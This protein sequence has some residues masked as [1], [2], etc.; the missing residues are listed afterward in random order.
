[1]SGEERIL[2]RWRLTREIGRGGMGQVWHAVLLENTTPDGFPNQAAIKILP[3]SLTRE[4]GIALRFQREM[5]I[6]GKLSH[7]GIVTFLEATNDGE[8]LG[9]AMEFVDGCSLQELLQSRGALDW[10]DVLALA[11][12]ICQPLKHAHDRG[13]IHRD[14]KPSNILVKGWPDCPQVKLTDFGVASLFASRKLTATGGL[15]G[16]AETIA[17]E[18]V[19]GKPAT[20]RSDLYSLGVVI[21]TL[22]T[23]QFP[24]RGHLAEVLHKQRFGQHERLSHLVNGLPPELERLVDE[25]LAKDP[26]ARPPDA[27]LVAR[28]LQVIARKDQ[29]TQGKMHPDLARASPLQGRD[30]PLEGEGPATFVSRIVR[31]HLKEQNRGGLW[32][33]MMRNP[34]IVAPMLGLVFAALVWVVWPPDEKVLLDEGIR[35]MESSDPLERR[36]GWENF[37]EPLY[38]RSNHEM[39]EVEFEDYRQKY[40]DALR[41]LEAQARTRSADVQTDAEWAYLCSR[42]LEGIGEQDAANRILH[43]IVIAYRDQ[44]LE[45]PWVRKAEAALGKDLAKVARS[46]PLKDREDALLFLDRGTA[47]GAGLPKGPK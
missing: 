36:R 24:F 42:R 27:G 8:S 6:L 5:E 21:Y 9:F 23:G 34:W 28:R 14:L 1:M 18:Q 30:F 47:L 17:P 29:F 45:T 43:A 22:I 25:L 40:Q 41:E 12:Q 31:D 26:S 37:L 39:P 44:P 7:P 33:R 16:T 35:L 46:F 32:S 3:A 11:I 13:V 15:V 10:E 20:K 4:P 38:T 2:G 19:A